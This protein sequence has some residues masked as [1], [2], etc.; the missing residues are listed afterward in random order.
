M[1]RKD[2]N[3]YVLQDDYAECFIYNLKNEPAGSFVI[4]IDDIDK[5]KKHRWSIIETKNYKRVVTYINNKRISLHKYIMDYYGKNP[6]D[7]INRNTLDNRKQNLRIVTDCENNANKDV[8]NIWKQK[9]GKYRVVVVR[10]GIRYHVGYFDTEEAALIA[11]DKKIKEIEKYS[12]EQLK[13]YYQRGGFKQTGISPS[14]SG[15]W[16]VFYGYGKT[17]KAIGT[18]DTF[19]LAKKAREEYITNIASI[20][21]R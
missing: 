9:N 5:C 2:H 17:R 13:N 20:S 7:H 15:K 18:F 6:I 21:N 10:Y 16:R 4:D 8:K 19:E 3:Q 11:R 12:D 1:N 14:P